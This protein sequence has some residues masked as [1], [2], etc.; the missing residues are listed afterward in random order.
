MS[1]RLACG[2]RAWT[3]GLTVLVASCSS[4]QE[5]PSEDGSVPAEKDASGDSHPDEPPSGRDAGMGAQ[6]AAGTDASQATWL[7][8][9]SHGGTIT[10]EQIGAP[11][12][13]P[14]RRDPSSGAC[15]AYASGSCCLAKQNVTSDALTPW[16]QD[17]VLTLRGPMLVKQ[18][19]V[20]Q[21]AEGAANW[22]R[23]S[24][25][26]EDGTASGLSFTGKP[27]TGGRFAGKIGS[28]CLVNVATDHSFGCGTGS[29]PYC[30]TNASDHFQGWAGSKLFLFLASMPHANSGAIDAPCSDNNQGNWYDAPWIGLSLGELVRAGSFSD[31]QCY[32]KDPSKW[33]LGDGCG[34]LNAFEVVND[35]NQY[36][37]LDVFSTNFF[38]YAGY[39]GEGPC[40]TGCNVS[41]LGA[42]VDLID[43]AKSQ[44]ATG[45]LASPMKGPGAAFRRPSAGYRWFMM[46]FDVSSRTVQL[47]LVH[48]GAVPSA[49]QKLLPSL[50]DTVSNETIANVRGLRLPAR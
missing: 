15:D 29:S 36:K 4:H 43:K 5:P 10:F 27:I 49:V 48:P 44:E 9:V 17:L 18:F 22:K 8:P 13:Y 6:N 46:L 38:G 23:V 30:P 11:G 33:Y 26:S 42:E 31:C 16:D 2:A 35:N 20:Y 14:S 41:K 1:L 19:A 21:P 39:V 34:Q 47:G 24:K 32:A 45:A 40:G 37:N 3:L 12:W 7:D 28:E 25:W 50:P